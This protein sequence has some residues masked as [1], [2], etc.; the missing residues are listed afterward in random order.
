MGLILGAHDELGD[1]EELWNH[2]CVKIRAD[3]EFWGW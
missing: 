3:K 1:S 2:W